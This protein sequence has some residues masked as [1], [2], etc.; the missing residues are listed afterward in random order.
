MKESFVLKETFEIEPSFLYHAWLDS[1]LHGQMTGGEAQCSNFEG[2]TFSA[3][4]GYI[5]GENIEL[6]KN[7]KIVQT[8]RTTEFDEKDEDSTL[9]I[10]LVEIQGGTAFILTHTNIP[11]GQSQYKQGWVDHYFSPMKEFISNQK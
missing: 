3:W 1:D 4:D 8:W 5:T 9:S 11:E 6:T 2:G 7:K 10:E